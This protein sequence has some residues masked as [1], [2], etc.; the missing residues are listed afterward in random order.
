MQYRLLALSSVLLALVA[1][2]PACAEDAAA[3]LLSFH[4]KPGATTQFEEALKQQMEARRAQKTPWRWLTW[5]YVSGELPRYCV[6]SFGHVWADFDQPTETVRAEEGRIA[7]AAALSS[8]PPTAQYYE[9]LE[10]VSDFGSASDAPRLAE[11]SIYRLH[12]GKVAQF[13]AALREFRDAMSRTGSG[14]RFEWFQ[15]RSGGDTPQFMLMVPRENWGAFDAST[16]DFYER[17]EKTFGKK[18]A[19]RVFDQFT[20]AVKS[21]ERSAV[22]LRLDLSLVPASGNPGP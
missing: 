11:I 20:S 19:K 22:R 9:H 4:V 18:K 13:Y 16:A 17:L 10:E 2:R 7:A 21:H 15:L 3:L 5:E 6:G 1:W 12:Y 14:Q 8:Q